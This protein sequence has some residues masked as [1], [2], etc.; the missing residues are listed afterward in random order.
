[1]YT[2]D[3]GPPGP[4]TYPLEIQFE[5]VERIT[6]NISAGLGTDYSQVYDRVYSWWMDM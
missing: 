2:V 5:K 1:M 3:D 4:L 6:A